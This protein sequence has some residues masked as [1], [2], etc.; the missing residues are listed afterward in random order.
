MT[1][2]L[3][4]QGW[5]VG[6]LCKVGVLSVWPGWVNDTVILNKCPTPIC[7][8]K[9]YSNV[10]SK[11]VSVAQWNYCIVCHHAFSFARIFF[12]Y[13]VPVSHRPVSEMFWSGRQ[14]LWM[15]A[16]SWPLDTS[17]NFQGNGKSPGDLSLLILT[18]AT[19]QRLAVNLVEGGTKESPGINISTSISINIR[20][21]TIVSISNSISIIKSLRISCS[22]SSFI[23][24]KNLLEYQG[25]LG[26]SYISSTMPSSIQVKVQHATTKTRQEGE[27]GYWITDVACVPS[28]AA[29]P[30]I[31]WLNYYCPMSTKRMAVH[32]GRQT[33]PQNKWGEGVCLVFTQP[34][35]LDM[36]VG[37]GRGHVRGEFQQLSY[38]LHST[39]NLILSKWLMTPLFGLATE[40]VSD[41]DLPDGW[42]WHRPASSKDI[43]SWLVPNTEV[44]QLFLQVVEFTWKYSTKTTD[45]S[46]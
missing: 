15:F 18:K 35:L 33:W 8:N 6:L 24:S 4:A 9:S 21:G 26:A 10:P 42:E 11:S 38:N 3:P 32:A 31:Y 22:V 45:S 12:I 40:K 7:C 39:T 25:N 34:H 37:R 20:F 1:S 23:F 14:P 5:M 44:D 13:G 36:L 43:W 28:F 41:F 46:S 19:A 2:W 16:A 17:T 30:N 29:A 27:E